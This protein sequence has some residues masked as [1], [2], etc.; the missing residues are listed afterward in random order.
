MGYERVPLE[1][2]RRA[3]SGPTRPAAN[4]LVFVSLLAICTLIGVD[5]GLHA[6]SL[7]GRRSFS[8]VDDF[9]QLARQPLLEWEQMHKASVAELADPETDQTVS[10]DVDESKTAVL[11]AAAAAAAVPHASPCNMSMTTAGANMS[12][13]MGMAQSVHPLDHWVTQECP[14]VRW[15]REFQRERPSSRSKEITNVVSLDM[16]SFPMAMLNNSLTAVVYLGEK[17]RDTWAETMIPKMQ[18]CPLVKEVLIDWWPESDLS[19]SKLPV[20]SLKKVRVADGKRGLGER[21]LIGEQITTP[22]TATFDDDRGFSCHLLHRLMIMAMRFPNKIA[23]L[24]EFGRRIM[25]CPSLNENQLQ[26]K[27]SKS[28]GAITLPVAAVVGTSS[29]VAY[30]KLMPRPIIDM[31]N[32]ELNCEDMALNWVVAQMAPDGQTGV[33]LEEKHLGA[34]GDYIDMDDLKG[35]SATVNGQVRRNAC[36][37]MLAQLLPQWRVPKPPK[38]SVHV[39]DPLSGKAANHTMARIVVVTAA[40]SENR[41]D[42]LDTVF[43]NQDM[44]CAL[45]GYRSVTIYGKDVQTADRGAYRAKLETILSLMVETKHKYVVWKDSDTLFM[46]CS[47]RLDLLVREYPTKDIIFTSDVSPWFVNTG[48]MIFKRTAFAKRF[49][50]TVL[51]LM[52]DMPA[53]AGSLPGEQVYINFA[54]LDAARRKA[55]QQDIR[56]CMKACKGLECLKHMDP[57]LS[58]HIAVLPNHALQSLRSQR[59]IPPPRLVPMRVEP[60]VHITTPTPLPTTRE[61]GSEIAILPD[62]QLVTRKA[63]PQNATLVKH[64]SGV[65]NQPP[66]RRRRRRRMYQQQEEVEYVAEDGE[67]VFIMHVAGAAPKESPEMRGQIIR[68]HA[69]FSSC[70]AIKL[71]SDVCI[72]AA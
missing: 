13:S 38:F 7:L 30:A 14:K 16:R 66:R 1:V 11:S 27:L 68:E 22:F 28:K 32:K 2:H 23:T 3:T 18:A 65:G 51:K 57:Y 67:E 49:L 9:L 60:H 64:A 29:L 36:L 42:F 44:Y 5:I 50:K 41:P 35:L 62:G 26:Y 56:P 4:G 21:W 31:M 69:M 61:S 17:R 43:E 48:V 72:T 15:M 46:D 55:C 47:K 12:M 24:S 54:L 37:N 63:V 40:Y 52:S 19:L 8:S 6:G 34:T 71:C 53:P 39:R 70:P 10:G 33:V 59:L 20:K 25:H 58:R 45:H